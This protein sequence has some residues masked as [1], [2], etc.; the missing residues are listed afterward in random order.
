MSPIRASQTRMGATISASLHL[1]A[2]HQK[3]PKVAPL[4]RTSTSDS[5]CTRMDLME[6]DRVECEMQT[7]ID[8]ETIEIDDC[9]Y[10]V[11][12][13]LNLEYEAREKTR[14]SSIYH[15]NSSDTCITYIIIDPDL[16]ITYQTTDVPFQYPN[17]K[18]S[19]HTTID[20]TFD[21][22]GECSGEETSSSTD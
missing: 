16:H 22:K 18:F 17:T 10:E 4:E 12:R 19:H 20:S 2:H 5:I 15:H 7:E 8:I 13:D 1:T 21:V 14:R 6:T 11:C 3:T 9:Y